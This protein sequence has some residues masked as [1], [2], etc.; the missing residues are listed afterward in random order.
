[1]RL[2][3]LFVLSL[4]VCDEFPVLA[5]KTGRVGMGLWSELPRLFVRL[6]RRVLVTTMTRRETRQKLVEIRHKFTLRRFSG[7]V[8]GENSTEE[9]GKALHFSSLCGEVRKVFRRKFTPEQ[10]TRQLPVQ[11]G[12]LVLVLR[13]HWI[14]PHRKWTVL[15]LFVFER[16]ITLLFTSVAA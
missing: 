6:S 15:S 13:Q 3:S 5:W 4:F 7:R 8:S 16:C 10:K 2:L 12:F 1:M 11:M 14:D 9:R